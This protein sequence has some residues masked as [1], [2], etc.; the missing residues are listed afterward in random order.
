MD[1]KT[2]THQ[3]WKII[4]VV[5]AKTNQDLFIFYLVVLTKTQFEWEILCLSRSSKSNLGKS[6]WDRDFIE[7]LINDWIVFQLRLS[8]IKV[9]FFIK[10]R[11][12]IKET[13][14]IPVWE[15]W[16]HQSWMKTQMFAYPV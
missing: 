14:F 13:L 1:V 3:D 8:Y 7:S 16:Y 15:N 4:W 5:E 11:L 9:F 6:F 2:E 12:N 10:D